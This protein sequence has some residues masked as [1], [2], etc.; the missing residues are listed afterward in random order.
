VVEVG[1]K[2]LG[3]KRMFLENNKVKVPFRRLMQEL[4]FQVIQEVSGKGEE[5]SVIYRFGKRSGRRRKLS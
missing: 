4:G 3:V 1:F 2:E 5:G